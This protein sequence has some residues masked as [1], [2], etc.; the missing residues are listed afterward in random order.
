M[1]GEVVSFP[2]SDRPV[3]PRPRGKGA[4]D[5]RRR[6]STVVRS[7][8]TTEKRERELEKIARLLGISVSLMVDNILGQ[9]LVM[10]KAGKQPINR[11]DLTRELVGKLHRVWNS[12]AA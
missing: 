7:F 10:A 9:A 11:E 1:Q 6:S 4:L 8:R 5:R 12:E 2:A 3:D